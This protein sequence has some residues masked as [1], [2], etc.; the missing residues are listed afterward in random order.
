MT[1]DS[2][3]TSGKKSFQT[4]RATLRGDLLEPGVDGYDVSRKIWN[5]IIDK[6]PSVI[7]KCQGVADIITCVNYARENKLLL[8]VKGGGHH[9][10][11]TA[12]CDDGLMIDLS[13]MDGV[14]VDPY[15]K[16]ARVQSGATWGEVDH[17]TQEF[18][19][20][21]VGGQDPNI[22]VAGMTLGGGVGWLS[23]KYGL[24]IDNL[25]EVDLVTA[26]GRFVTASEAHH[27]ELFWALRGGGGNF[28]VATSFKFQLHNVGPE[29]LAGSLIHPV[30]C[31]PELTEFYDAFTAE[32]PDELRTLF[33]IMVLGEGAHLPP[34]LYNEQ[35]AIIVSLY[36]GD[37]DEGVADLAPLRNFGQPIVDS[38]RKRPYKEFQQ[39]GTS[40]ERWR[41]YLRS[42][43]LD[44][45]SPGIIDILME[46][47]RGI[48]SKESTVFISHRG[49]AETRPAVDATAYP[50]REES[51]HV[52]IEARWEDPDRDDEHISWVQGFHRELQ[53]YSIDGPAMNFLTSDESE[54]RVNASYGQN[55]EKLVE[56]KNE[57]DPNNLF[58]MNQ[59]IRPTLED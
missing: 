25:L 42:Q 6:H 26:D 4:L 21:T 27:S 51:H 28:G 33:G 9:V 41:T 24:T 44:E 52:L 55:Y 2:S 36:A 31:V 22:G 48:P 45:L 54:K 32:A 3:H 58:R 59:N 56:V 8:S 23:R 46:Y 49:G 18:G 13:D 39:A 40:D 11:G 53:P 14:W 16:T 47:S 29:V 35:V 1:S 5:A 12:V 50:H 7:A 37:P 34:E 38:I 57:W 19:L 30:E 17:E 15:S 10:S 43:Y 20:A